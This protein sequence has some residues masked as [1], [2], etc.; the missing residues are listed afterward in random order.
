MSAGTVLKRFANPR[1]R[2]IAALTVVG[3]LVCS[4]IIAFAADD[5]ALSGENNLVNPVAKETL[6][7]LSATSQRPLFAPTRRPFAPDPP[8]PPPAEA[9]AP[10]PPPPPNVTLVGVVKDANVLQALLRLGE[11]DLHVKIGDD[12]SGWTVADIGARSL[13]LT[14]GERTVSLNLFPEKPPAVAAG[15]AMKKRGGAADN[16]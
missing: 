2:G 11:K 10:Q 12:L 16:Q 15:S 6:Q 5:A 8:P 4:S 9:P 7:N 14:L 3:A 13:V 1:R